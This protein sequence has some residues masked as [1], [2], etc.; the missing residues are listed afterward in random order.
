M[1]FHMPMNRFRSKSKKK[2]SIVFEMSTMKFVFAGREVKYKYSPFYSPNGTF[3]SPSRDPFPDQPIFHLFH[4]LDSD[5]QR[6]ILHYLCCWEVNMELMEIPTNKVLE[7][8]LPCPYITVRQLKELIVSDTDK[9]IE[10]VD[11]GSNRRCWNGSKSIIEYMDQNYYIPR[12]CYRGPSVI[13][14]PIDFA[15]CVRRKR[16]IRAEDQEPWRI[17]L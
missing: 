16:E 2:Y 14:P 9:T 13:P 10:M 8:V 17:P 4:S 7:V 5:L 1:S 6:R 15:R 11:V 3:I 12:F